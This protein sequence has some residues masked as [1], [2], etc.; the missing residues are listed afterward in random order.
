[1]RTLGDHGWLNAYIGIP[2]EAGG[3]GPDSYDCYGLCMAIY[4]DVFEIDLPD[5]QGDVNCIAD[6]T[7]AIDDVVNTGNW[8]DLEEPFDGCFVICARQKAS[9]HLGL[10]FA[11]GVVHA[12]EGC[13]VIYEPLSRFAERFGKLKF[14]DWAP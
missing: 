12:W 11:G 3:R 7:E 1:M 5:W 6:R 4:A 8:M 9:Y 2:Y 14:G 10:Y 13:G